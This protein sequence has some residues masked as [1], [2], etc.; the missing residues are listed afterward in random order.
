MDSQKNTPIAEEP[1]PKSEESDIDEETEE[2][3]SAKEEDQKDKNQELKVESRD[4][5]RAVLEWQYN[6]Y[7]HLQSLSR[8]L[9]GTLVAMVAILVS[10]SITFADQLKSLPP[11]M[12]PQ[13]VRAA[14]GL[15]VDPIGAFLTVSL[16]SILIYTLFLLFFYSIVVSTLRFY[17]VFTDSG[18]PPLT[19]VKTQEKSD[20]RDLQTTIQENQEYIEKIHQKYTEG[21]F[22]ILI[23]I[24]VIIIISFIYYYSTQLQLVNLIAYDFLL[25]IPGSATV[26]FWKKVLG[27][28]GDE[29]VEEDTVSL[30]TE[31]VQEDGGRWSHVEFHWVE[32]L[33]FSITTLIT[34][35]IGIIW[36]IAFLN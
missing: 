25:L 23:F 1:R 9:F 2:T 5:G 33:L 22:R 29:Q 6:R 34:F 4:D 36:A 27:N 14:K 24:S 35:F 10:V 16:N 18:L 28:N 21:A 8:G 17:A 32:N 13:Y 11:E 19:L 30:T 12:G 7:Q 15:P 31:F 26:K 20:V 3:T